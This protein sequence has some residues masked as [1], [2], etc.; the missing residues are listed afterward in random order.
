MISMGIVDPEWAL[1]KRDPNVPAWEEVEYR[2]WQAR[3]MEVYAAQVD[4]MDQGIGRIV[5]EFERID[6]FDDTLILF[7][8]D[9]GGC[10]E[11]IFATWNGIG[12]RSTILP[13]KIRSA[14][15]NSLV[16]GTRGRS[17]RVCCPGRGN[18]HKKATPGRG[19]AG[20][21]SGGQETSSRERT[22]VGILS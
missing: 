6:A 13:K 22:R 11:E 15:S 16:I 12:P 17:G 8:S 7:L 5:S 21:Q 9:N 3:R 19:G 4:R 10:Q 2:K 14:S 20:A 18:N 1:S